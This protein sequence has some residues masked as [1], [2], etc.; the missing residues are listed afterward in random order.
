MDSYTT[1]ELFNNIKAKGIVVNS[2]DRTAFSKCDYF[3]VLNAYKGLFIAGVESIDN[4]VS[5]IN[6]G[7]DILRYQK[8]FRIKK[9]ADSNDLKNKICDYIVSKYGLKI[10]KASSLSEK[11]ASIKAIKY[12]HH[13]YKPNTYFLDF[14]RMYEFEHDL[15]MLLMKYTLIIENNIKRIFISYLNDQN[16]PSDYLVD[17]SNY[18]TS[19][20]VNYRN[21]SIES[22]KKVVDLFG[23][24]HSHPIKHKRDQNL[25]VPYWILINEMTLNQTLSTIKNLNNIDRDHVFQKCLQE[26]TDC[27]TVDVFDLSG[28][29]SSQIQ[30]ENNCIKYFKFVIRYIGEFRNLLAHN[31]PIFNYN[32]ADTSLNNYPIFAFEYPSPNGRDSR[33]P[34]VQQHSMNAT[35]MGYMKRFF[36]TDWYNSRSSDINID[37]SFII[38]S[39][40]RISNRINNANLFKTELLEIFMKYNVII[41]YPPLYGM[42][43]QQVLLM[44][45]RIRENMVDLKAIEEVKRCIEEGKSYKKRMNKCMSDVKKSNHVIESSINAASLSS[46]KSKYSPFLNT[47]EYKL[48]TNIDA[49]FLFKL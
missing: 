9:F 6:S 19:G 11:T 37:L 36:G 41:S 49:T 27:K 20:P 48:F 47:N 3:Q 34:I 46:R 29:S 31:Q 18:N 4:I 12:I 40:C 2:K 10:S 24:E 14:F 15:R 30:L 25:I 23:N 7:V 42:D 38:Y 17:I 32:I 22:I 8:A 33:P 28:K 13:I 45:K 21:G 5:N 26:F 39:I 16:K 44:I 43:Y 1:K 35:L